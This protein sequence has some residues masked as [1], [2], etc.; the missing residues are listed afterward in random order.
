MR[1]RVRECVSERNK[2]R[3]RVIFSRRRSISL[4]VSPDK[5]VTVRAPFR[6]SLRSIERFVQEKSDWIRK[7]LEKHSGLTRINQGKKYIDGESYLFIG[8]ENCLRIS[9]SVKQFVRQNDNII[10]VGLADTSDTMKIKSLLDRWYRQKAQERFSVL[11]EEILTRFSEQ[12]FSPTEFVVKPLKSRWGSCSSK[13]RIT[14]SSELIK[15]KENFAEYVI[16]H[17]LCHLKHHNHGKDYY[18]L[19]EKL[20]PDY[21]TIRKDLRKFITR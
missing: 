17:E 7:H 10:E 13:G 9:K 3:Y 2:Q 11:L 14:I 5:G 21:K 1:G 19:L 16:I 4:I 12:R 15:L 8:R 20:V 6:T 18:R